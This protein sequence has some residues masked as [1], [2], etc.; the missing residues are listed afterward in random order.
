MVDVVEPFYLHLNAA[1]Y[2]DAVDSGR[3]LRQAKKRGDAFQVD[4]R[5]L[6]VNGSGIAGGTR[7]ATVQLGQ[8]PGAFEPDQ[9]RRRW[10]AGTL[11]ADF[12]RLRRAMKD[13]I[14]G[15]E[16]TNPKAAGSKGWLASLACW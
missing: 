6:F 3:Q 9:D 13:S 4:V 15:V 14:S 7:A 8:S 5:P 2:R 16:K 12:V 1:L 11:S 10:R